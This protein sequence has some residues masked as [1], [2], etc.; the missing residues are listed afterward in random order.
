[1]G[2]TVER[3]PSGCPEVNKSGHWYRDWGKTT[4]E[5]SSSPH[6]KGSVSSCLQSF[7]LVVCFFA[8]G[9]A[10]DLASLL[11]TAQESCPPKP[12]LSPHHQAVLSKGSSVLAFL[13]QYIPSAEHHDFRPLFTPVRPSRTDNNNISLYFAY[14]ILSSLWFWEF[15]KTILLFSF[16]TYKK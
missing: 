10:S 14:F 9:T 11:T 7:S 3:K 12:H 4:M 6:S 2:A 1:M 15:Y 5:S 8:F 13:P 16:Y